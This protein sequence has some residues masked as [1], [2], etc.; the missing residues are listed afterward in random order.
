MSRDTKVSLENGEK[1]SVA[2]AEDYTWERTTLVKKE[3]KSPR[4]WG[5]MG[6]ALQK[7]SSGVRIYFDL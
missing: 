7:P 4:S 5:H 3:R 2:S 1:S 6:E